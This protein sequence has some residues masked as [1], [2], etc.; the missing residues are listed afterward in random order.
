MPVPFWTAAQLH[1]HREHVALH[2]L[3]LAGYEVYL[4]RIAERRLIR[5]RRVDGV[6]ALFPTYAFVLVVHHW[7]NTSHAPG[8]LK[9]V[10]DGARPARVPDSAIEAIKAREKRGLVV[11]PDPPRLRA[12]TRVR[13]VSGPFA[14]RGG[15]ILLHSGLNGRERVIVL[16]AALGRIEVARSAVEVGGA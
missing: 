7:W 1:G 6:Q 2:A 11:L 13:V 14:G 8:V 9:L 15:T 4:P 12:G 3:G 5:G 10:M 16:L